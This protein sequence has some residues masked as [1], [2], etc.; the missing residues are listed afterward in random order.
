MSRTIHSL[1]PGRSNNIASAMRFMP[2][3]SYMVNSISL[4]LA[5]EAL[6]SPPPEPVFSNGCPMPS[7]PSI[8]T[9]ISVGMDMGDLEIERPVS[10][11]PPELRTYADVL[12]GVR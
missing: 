6:L 12:M 9:C 7:A 4:T 5:L 8:G 1:G 11:S 10:L 2:P 3:R